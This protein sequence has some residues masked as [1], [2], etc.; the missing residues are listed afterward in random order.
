MNLT[1]HLTHLY[2]MGYQITVGCRGYRVVKD[3]VAL[4]HMGNPEGKLRTPITTSER[5]QYEHNVVCVLHI[6]H[7]HI[8]QDY[9][10]TRKLHFS[11]ES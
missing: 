5:V 6:C 7:G 10:N 3:G 8:A 4:G 2:D 1:K 9:M 11:S